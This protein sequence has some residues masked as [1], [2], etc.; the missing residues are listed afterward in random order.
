MAKRPEPNDEDRRSK[1]LPQLRTMWRA[2]IE[3]PVRNPLLLL[4]GLLLGVVVATSFAQIR[5]NVWN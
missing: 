1:L 5:L 3:S 4:G 2:L